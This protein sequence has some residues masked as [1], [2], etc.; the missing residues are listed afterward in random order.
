MAFHI[1]KD[2]AGMWRWYLVNET[3]RKIAISPE[4]YYHRVDCIAAI[5]KVMITNRQ[6]RIFED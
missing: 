5:S 1:F 4:G 2:S 6:T 3:Y